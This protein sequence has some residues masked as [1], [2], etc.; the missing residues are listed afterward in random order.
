MRD[1]R[2]CCGCMCMY[3]CFSQV[4]A[5][6]A[7]ARLV[8]VRGSDEIFHILGVILFFLGFFRF[9]LEGSCGTS[10]VSLGIATVPL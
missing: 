2:S 10:A 5:A 4:V 8:F 3:E 1:L 9:F 6:A 7:L